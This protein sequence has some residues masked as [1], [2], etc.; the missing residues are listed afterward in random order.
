[1]FQEVK[2]KYLQIKL[3][4]YGIDKHILKNINVKLKLIYMLLSIHNNKK[5]YIAQ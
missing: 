3:F 4:F 5:C 1:M 2:K